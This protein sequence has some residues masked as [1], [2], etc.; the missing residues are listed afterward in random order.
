MPSPIP[1]IAALIILLTL[2][3]LVFGGIPAIRRLRARRISTFQ[4]TVLDKKEETTMIYAGVFIPLVIY[5]LRVEK[6]MEFNVSHATYSSVNI[7]DTVSISSY[8]DGS[9]RLDQ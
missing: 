1:V 8:S 6:G 2:I 5:H 4:S 3:A 9:H 7:G